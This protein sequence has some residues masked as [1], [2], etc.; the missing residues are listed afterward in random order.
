M[1]YNAY[2]VNQLKINIRNKK[3]QIND[4]TYLP[5]MVGNHILYIQVDNPYLIRFQQ[6]KCE[7]YELNS[8]KTIVLNQDNSFILMMKIQQIKKMSLFL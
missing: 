4:N 8:E 3:L 5:H 6:G 2:N 7:V 1:S